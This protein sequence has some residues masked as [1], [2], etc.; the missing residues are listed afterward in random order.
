MSTTPRRPR[1]LALLA[2]SA[3]SLACSDD[4]NGPSGIEGTY[5]LTRIADRAMPTAVF[6]GIYYDDDGGPHD[7]LIR[8][9]SGRLTL[10][11][12]G[13]RYVHRVDLIGWVDGNPAVVSDVNDHGYCERAGAVLV[14]ESN[15]IEN[16]AFMAQIAGDDL[17]IVQDLSGE[18]EP[19][20]Y[21]YRR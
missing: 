15:Y 6:D 3:F 2:L 10:T 4:P 18:G 20:P 19:L 12:G 11:H 16:V 1:L 17:T 13:T 21:L 9:T 5:A 14:C 7:M 8:A